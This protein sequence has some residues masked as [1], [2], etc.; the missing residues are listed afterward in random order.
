MRA[1]GAIA[2]G[3]PGRAFAAPARG[4]GG[5]PTRGA[6]EPDGAPVPAESAHGGVP[7]RERPAN[8][9]S[10]RRRG[11]WRVTR[12]PATHASGVTAASPGCWTHCT[13]GVTTQCAPRFAS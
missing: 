5:P 1:R 4:R 3:R 9:R 12:R 11:Y 13:S 8:S 7:G 10:M 2:P 6:R